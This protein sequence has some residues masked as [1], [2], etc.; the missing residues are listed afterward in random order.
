MTSYS[1]LS[2]ICLENAEL[3]FIRALDL[4]VVFIS[5]YSLLFL[6]IFSNLNSKIC[7]EISVGLQ[8]NFL[9]FLPYFNRNFF[10]FIN[11]KKLIHCYQFL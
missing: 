6:E 8:L 3:F 11:L 7:I 1:F 4:N 10:V 9:L 5:L 2:F